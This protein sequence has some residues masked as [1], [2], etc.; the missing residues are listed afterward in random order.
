ME[1]PVPEEPDQERSSRDGGVD[2]MDRSRDRFGRNF[3]FRVMRMPADQDDGDSGKTSLPSSRSPLGFRM[4][5]PSVQ[6]FRYDG[7]HLRA[8]PKSLIGLP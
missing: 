4:S 3:F 1:G 8:F 7:G 2:Q 5:S 6:D